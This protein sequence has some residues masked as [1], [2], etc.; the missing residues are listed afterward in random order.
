MVATAPS[1]SG[2]PDQCHVWC[3]SCLMWGDDV[4]ADQAAEIATTHA[5]SLDHPANQ[6]DDLLFA[7]LSEAVRDER[8][9]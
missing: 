6:L 2:S 1:V 3:T 5:A 8:G 7:V 9:Y 4:P